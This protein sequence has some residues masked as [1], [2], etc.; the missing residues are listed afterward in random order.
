M[1]VTRTARVLGRFAPR[2]RIRLTLTTL[3]VVILPLTLL[4]AVLGLR[5]YENAEEQSLRIQRQSAATAEAEIRSTI[6][7]VETQ[8][9]LLDDTLAIGSIAVVEQEGVLSNLLANN[10]IYQE[11]AI[12]GIG[13]DVGV[14]VS[15][16]GG[17]AEPA[18]GSSSIRDAIASV[19]ASRDSHFGAV[20][21]NELLR[22]PLMPIAVPLENRRTGSVDSLL[23]ASVRFKEIW[24]LLGGL[25]E[26]GASDVYLLDRDG[27]VIAH[28]NPAIVLA[29]TTLESFPVAG[30]SI[31]L[32][33]D[34][35]VVATRPLDVGAAQIVVVAEQDVATALRLA[36]QGLRATIMFTLAGLVVTGALV[37]LVARYIVR[38]VEALAESAN[39]ITAGD[40]DHRAEVGADGE[41]SE[42]ARAFNTMTDRLGGLISSLEDQVA[43]RTEELAEAIA[44]QDQLILELEAQA[45][46]DHLTGLPNRFTLERHLDAELARANRL[47]SKVGVLLVDLDN[48]K[49]VNDTFGHGV[50]D[51]LLIAVGQRLRQTVR[52][53]DLVCRL[54]GDEFAV[55][56]A[57]VTSRED[58]ER[59]TMR[60]VDAFSEPIEIDQ[61]GIYTG[62]SIGVAITGN[63]RLSVSEVMQQADLALYRAKR[64]GRNTFRFF[65]GAMDD[66][67]KR[68]MRLNQTMRQAI[69]GDEFLLEYQPQV[70]ISDQRVLGA[71]ALLRWRHPELGLVTPGELV[72]IAEGSGLID[73]V[74]AWVLRATCDQIRR[75]LDS[76]LAV[77]PVAVNVS[78]FQLRV[79]GFARTVLE[80]LDATG[81]PADLLE[82]ELT[83]SVLMESGPHVDDTIRTL[84]DAGVGFALDD[85]G[86]G[87]ASLDYVRRFPFTKVKID[88]AFI[89]DLL[90]NDRSATVVGTVIELAARLD[91]SVVAEGVEHRELLDHL[92]A[93]GCEVAQ[94]FYFSRPLPP[95][96]FEDFLAQR[97]GDSP[98]V[99][100]D[101]PRSTV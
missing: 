48:F 87:Y 98:M 60:V 22:E 69:A 17:A 101:V 70:R 89:H 99:I 91:L 82:L 63:E 75:W 24:G 72:P 18:L 68:R 15:R 100:D 51:Q 14:R 27:V 42:L 7:G 38:P 66:E 81:L 55:V 73:A 74:G 28:R 32:D 37:V 11:L 39:R 94:G 65:E 43:Q 67:I 46:N 5:A 47:C 31:G 9:E 54:G 92:Q 84:H 88:R 76:G 97:L 90:T 13:G 58:V 57:D 2:L 71:E 33:G 3:A 25:A 34:D 61:R 62:V 19:E 21:F 50:G 8:L 86:R 6:L 20:T 83:E 30:R 1:T 78:A 85:F 40:L 95:R 64:A 16:T 59:M 93:R 29:G 49:D 79:P 12:V 52:E 77:P 10:R 44:V 4:A 26:P 80:L 56:Q 41:I 23:V 96:A 35:T 53:V 36:D 45:A